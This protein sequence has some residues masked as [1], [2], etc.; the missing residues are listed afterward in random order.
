[1]VFVNEDFEVDE[2]F[3][4]FIAQNM[5][6]EMI[7]RQRY[8]PSIR[9]TLSTLSPD[10]PRPSTPPRAFTWILPSKKTS[11]RETKRRIWPSRR[12]SERI[13]R[14]AQQCKFNGFR[15]FG[16]GSFV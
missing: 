7:Y 11:R 3:E 2:S 9:S 10:S 4:N 14:D 6:I 12:D 13:S 16:T 5:R 8:D 15:G 1:M